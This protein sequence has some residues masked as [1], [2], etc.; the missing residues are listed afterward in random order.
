MLTEGSVFSTRQGDGGQASK[1]HRLLFLPQFYS[2][3]RFLGISSYIGTKWESK[4]IRLAETIK[5]SCNCLV[6][7]FSRSSQI[8]LALKIYMLNVLLLMSTT[9]PGMTSGKQRLIIKIL[10]Y[11][12]YLLQ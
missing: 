1:P 8:F 12:Q 5:A 4:L 9:V 2:P 6:L 10:L 3:D 11:L 7:F